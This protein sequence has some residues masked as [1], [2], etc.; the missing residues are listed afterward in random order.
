MQVNCSKQDIKVAFISGL[1]LKK[2]FHDWTYL[3]LPTLLVSVCVLRHV[4][5]CVLGK[6]RET[7]AKN[8]DTGFPQQD[9]FFPFCFLLFF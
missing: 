8:Q 3:Y 5:L 7:I 9:F 2:S 1:L 4:I 6:D